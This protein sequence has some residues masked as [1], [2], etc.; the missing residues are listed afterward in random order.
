METICSL[1]KDTNLTDLSEYRCI[2]L[3]IKNDASG[4][5]RNGGL[6]QLIAPS[7]TFFRLPDMSDCVK[8][9]LH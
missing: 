1:N 6:V 9:Y 5:L 7:R 2:P 8:E 3:P 4:K